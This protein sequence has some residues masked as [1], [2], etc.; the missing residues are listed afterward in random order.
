MEA[1]LAGGRI[2]CPRCGGHLAP[3]G[4][5]SEREVR[6]LTG[7]TRLRPRRAIC[8]SCG[9]TQVLEPA[10]TLPRRRDAAEVIVAAWRHRASGV[11]QRQIAVLVARPLSTVRRWLRELESN[12]EGLRS[13]A[14]RR[15]HEFDPC[16]PVLEPT[17]SA[18]GDALEALGQAI[19]AAVRVVGPS[20]PWPLAVTLTGGLVARAG[21]ARRA[22]VRDGRSPSENRRAA[23]ARSSP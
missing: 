1:D 17:G 14:T 19:A 4:F 23:E 16:P 12:A 9:H 2:F 21:P 7:S 13:A 18:L 5:S 20:E 3:H 11:T 22:G 6:T 15:L 10:W 8:S